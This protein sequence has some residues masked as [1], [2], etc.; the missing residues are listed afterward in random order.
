MKAKCMMLK[1]DFKNIHIIPPAGLVRQHLFKRVLK[2]VFIQHVVKLYWVVQH[3]SQPALVHASV[4]ADSWG[5]VCQ[6]CST[7]ANRIQDRSEPQPMGR[8]MHAGS[9]SLPH[10]H[11]D[12]AFAPSAVLL[13]PAAPQGLL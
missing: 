3:F 6:G 5:L 7:R 13:L 11:L 12:A 8:K 2:S 10:N 1:L 9:C 4:A